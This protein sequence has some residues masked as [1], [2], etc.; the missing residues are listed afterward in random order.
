MMRLAVVDN[1]KNKIDI[2]ILAAKLMIDFFPKS[3]SLVNCC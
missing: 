1:N 2:K 3:V